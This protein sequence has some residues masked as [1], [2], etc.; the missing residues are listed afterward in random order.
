[1]HIMHTIH[2]HVCI[3][4]CPDSIG[5]IGHGLDK[6]SL[7]YIINCKSYGRNFLFATSKFFGRFRNEVPKVKY[8][9]ELTK[10]NFSQSSLKKV[11]TTFSLI[12]LQWQ[13]I[14]VW[15]GSVAC[16]ETITIEIL[17]M[18]FWLFFSPKLLIFIDSKKFGQSKLPPIILEQINSTTKLCLMRICKSLFQILIW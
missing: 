15:K 5:K 14:K 3:T 2:V 13:G 18:Q 10:R 8:C 16:L 4:N 1:M 12:Q 17:R 11:N 7:G 6:Q 9:H